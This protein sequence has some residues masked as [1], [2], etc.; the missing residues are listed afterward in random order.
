MRILITVSPLMY[1]ESLAL[2]IYQHRPD[3]EVRITLPEDSHE[4]VGRFDPHVLVRADNDG[5]D[6]LLLER[7]PCWVEV[8]YSD[9]MNARIAL[10][11]SIE[12][13]SDMPIDDLLRVVDEAE[14]FLLR[15]K[16][17]TSP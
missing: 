3:F 6:P 5:F 13:I 4:E 14:Q 16:R 2:A 15:G 10:D 9:H 11:G 1:R 7:I 12:E 8:M 17:G